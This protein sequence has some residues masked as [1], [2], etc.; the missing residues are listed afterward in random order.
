MTGAAPVAVVVPTFRRTE[1]LGR[2]LDA[3]AAQDPPPAQVVVVVRPEDPETAAW[4]GDRARGAPAVDLAVAVPGASAMA[5]L[6]EGVAQTVQPIVAFVD[7]DAAPRP[8]WLAGLLAHFEDPAVGA[9]G[10]RDVVDHPAHTGPPTTDVGRLTRWGRVVANHHLGT[11][12]ARDVAALKGVNMAFRAEALA[13]P[14]ALRGRGAQVHWELAASMWAA[15][16]GWRLVYDPAILVDHTVGPRFDDDRRVRPRPAAIAAVG[17][18]LVL[19]LG[20]FDRALARRRVL[21]GL[22]VGD[23]ETPG[24]VRALVALLR[25]EAEV[26]RRAVPAARGMLSALR[27]L[28]AGRTAELEPPR[29]QS[30]S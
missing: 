30:S 20:T 7:D 23:S 4:L 27:A 10:G 2:C 3:V 6:A 17:Y 12:A 22:V 21:F 8:G 29:P 1:L 19:V 9:V 11:G 25:R 15:S 14:R 26:L 24:A 5:A 13:L 28:H 16:R 18:N